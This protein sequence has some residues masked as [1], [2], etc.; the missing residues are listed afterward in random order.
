[1]IRLLAH[2]LPLS[3]P[4]VVSLSQSSC[5]TPIEITDGMGDGGGAILYDGEKAWSSVNHLILFGPEVVGT[6]S[7]FS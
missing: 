6:V 1:M 2:P 5:V 3:G 7:F 4:P